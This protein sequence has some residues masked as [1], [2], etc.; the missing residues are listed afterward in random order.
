MKAAKPT[1]L[2][3]PFF[4]LS[5]ALLLLNDFYLKY[6]FHN[7]FTGKL[8]DFTGLFAFTVFLL[9][10]FPSAK[11]T[12]I[13]IAA[14]FFC[15]W[16]SALSDP[17]IHF[18]NYNLSLPVSRI[19]D[20][21]DYCALLILP[22]CYL[23][24]PIDYPASLART[25]AIYTTGIV[26]LVSFCSTSLPRYMQRDTVYMNKVFRTRSKLE[27]IPE[28]FRQQNI[29]IVQDTAYYTSVKEWGN[30][31]YYL[32]IK[33]TSGTQKT[34]R[35]D[36]Y[37]GMELY[38]RTVPNEPTFTISYLVI[39]WDTIRNIR[40]S[41]SEMYTKK[42]RVITLESFAHDTTH[43]APYWY[44]ARRKYQKPIKKRIE[45]ILE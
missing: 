45:K 28:K 37:K 34:I 38:R 25:I 41:V 31:D 2:L 14:L 9:A 32:K 42:K 11:K 3:H 16:K 8:S 15:W 5:L 20:Y 7:G 39:N 12:I 13:L 6:Q 21:S 44:H 43:W 36:D 30:E 27:E 33:D 26:S 19:I 23:I 4:L 29:S 35:I 18:L 17:L 22:F 24:R 10:L 1:L 40:F